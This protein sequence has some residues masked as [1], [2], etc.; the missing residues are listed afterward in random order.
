MYKHLVDEYFIKETLLNH[1][2]IITRLPKTQQPHSSVI[3]YLLNNTKE[4]R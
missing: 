2:D 1:L 4:K 3:F